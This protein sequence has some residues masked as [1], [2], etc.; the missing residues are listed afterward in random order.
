MNDGG[1][2]HKVRYNRGP[3]GPGVQSPP[4]CWCIGSVPVLSSAWREDHNS[5]QVRQRSQLQ[6]VPKF[7]TPTNKEVS[8]TTNSAQQASP[9]PLRLK[10]S[11]QAS[12]TS[13]RLRPVAACNSQHTSPRP[14]ESC[15]TPGRVRW[16]SEGEGDGGGDMKTNEH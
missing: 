12:P 2:S 13:I 10:S 16:Q 9:T 5:R 4:P 11:R 1:L 3:V 6:Q 14:T 15:R 8:P 7:A